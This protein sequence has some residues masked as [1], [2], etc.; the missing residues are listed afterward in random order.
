MSEP[1]RRQCRAV[2]IAHS[3]EE[4]A[5]ELEANEGLACLQLF[6]RREL[7]PRDLPVLRRLS[8]ALEGHPGV[9]DLLLSGFRPAGGQEE[10][11]EEDD[12]DDESAAIARIVNP[13]RRGRQPRPPP[14]QV[15]LDRLFGEIVPRCSPLTEAIS[16][17]GCESRSVER[18]AS[19]LAAGA[20]D[21]GRGLGELYVGATPLEP[22]CVEAIAGLF[23]RNAPVRKLSMGHCGLDPAACKAICD[24]LAGNDHVRELQLC[25]MF[26]PRG[27]TFVEALGPRSRLKCLAVEADW[28]EEGFDSV[29]ECL[30][31][32]EELER[33]RF[34][35]FGPFRWNPL[36]KLEG[37]VSKY[38]F[39][40]E[41]VEALPSEPYTA[42]YLQRINSSLLL[43]V[44]VRRAHSHLRA[45]QYR[46][47]QRSAWP[48]ALD[49]ISSKPALLF[50][51]LRRGNPDAWADPRAPPRSKRP[52]RCRCRAPGARP[53]R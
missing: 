21:R 8:S 50:R 26:E 18:L 13:L 9:R 47:R 6:L 25:E 12:G 34:W 22:S 27:D 10:Q 51:F 20:A 2:L 29:V 46:I 37:L 41:R 4:A 17:G 45:R 49:R 3:L 19:A 23:R 42:P 14:L 39:T 44:R 38:N 53:R 30:K 52:L 1:R 7:K 35:S 43:N 16:L 11:E 5:G 48:L 28:T 31:F 32:N 24:S 15:E 40:L 36:R 33:I